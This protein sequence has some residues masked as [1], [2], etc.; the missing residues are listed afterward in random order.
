M[1]IL[2]FLFSLLKA[3]FYKL[4]HIIFFSLMNL[5]HIF[6]FG[7][8]VSKIVT[9]LAKGVF[10]KRR[11]LQR[12]TR[13]KRETKNYVD[14]PYSGQTASFN[15]EKLK[16]AFI[17]LDSRADRLEHITSE[18][19]KIGLLGASRHSAVKR[20]N[21][22]LGCSL[23]HYQ[24]LSNAALESDELLMVC[25]DDC[26]FLDSQESL[27]SIL[28]EFLENSA[29]DVLC[30]AYNVV[31][32]HS[33]VPISNLLAVTNNTQTT[34]CYVLKPHM[35]EPLLEVARESSVALEMGKPMSIFAIDQLW[36]TLQNSYF[37]AIPRS[38]FAR[39]VESHSDI[40]GRTVFYGV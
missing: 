15:F 32:N 2:S 11:L 40:E 12:Y 18:F 33:S 23:S 17:N 21:G 24:V 9:T 13:R 22:A 4:K 16:I 30:L 3:V 14:R 8:R 28:T 39:Q 31:G 26:Q 10:A 37:F 19:R 1:R 38:R 20:D 25:E 7:I 29:L 5:K 34:A 27:G 35:I 36:K 6:Y